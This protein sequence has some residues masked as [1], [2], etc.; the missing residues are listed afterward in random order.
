MIK[1]KLPSPDW[2]YAGNTFTGSYR[3]D[4]TKGCFNQTTFYYTVKLIHTPNRTCLAAMCR[5]MLPWNQ[6]SNIDEACI[7]QFQPDAF[8]IEV[9]EEWILRKILVSNPSHFEQISPPSLSTST[10][11]PVCAKVR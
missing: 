8:G 3:P 6:S 11:E 4:P 10:L 1:I 7:A 5:F 9:A 2:F